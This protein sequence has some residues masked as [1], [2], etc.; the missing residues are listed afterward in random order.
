VAS[1]TVR[2]AEGRQ[3]RQERPEQSASRKAATER[4]GSAGSIS[5]PSHPAHPALSERVAG[6]SARSSKRPL[7]QGGLA[8]CLLNGIYILD[9]EIVRPNINC[10]ERGMLV[11]L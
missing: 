11:Y 4:R 3:R 6:P 10:S 1:S 8:G 7:I 9:T 5:S 2:R